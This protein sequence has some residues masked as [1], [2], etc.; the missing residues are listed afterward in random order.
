MGLFGKKRVGV[1][2]LGL[3]GSRVA[4]NLRQAGH[5]VFVWNR[6]PR[7]EPNFLGSIE[8]LARQCPV[9][10][11]FVS[12]DEALGSCCG[13][14]AG[15]VGSRHVIIN[16]ATVSPQA[17]A[18]AAQRVRAAGA[19]FLNAPFTGSRQAAEEAQL[20]YYVGGERGHLESVRG[21]LDASSR[22]ILHVG[23]IEDAAVLKIATNLVSAAINQG[24]A[25]ALALTTSAGLS[26]ERLVEAIE[27]NAARS[28]VSDLKLPKMIAGDY[29][30][31]FELRHMFKDVSFAIDLA[32]R[33][34]TDLPVANAAAACLLGA[35]TRGD[36]GSDFAAVYKSFAGSAAGGGG[37]EETQTADASVAAAA[38]SAAAAIEP[39][40]EPAS[41]SAAQPAMPAGGGEPVEAQAALVPPANAGGEADPPELFE[42]VEQA[43][44]QAAVPADEQADETGPAQSP[45]RTEVAA[46]EQMQPQ[47][48]WRIELP[49]AGDHQEPQPQELPLSDAHSDEQDQSA[50]DRREPWPEAGQDEPAAGEPEQASEPEQAGEPEQAS[51]SEPSERR[52][53][54][55]K[56]ILPPREPADDPLTATSYRQAEAEDDAP[57][58]GS[59][60]AA[61]RQPPVEPVPLQVKLPPRAD[62]AETGTPGEAVQP[63]APPPTP[64]T[65]PP[66]SPGGSHEQARAGAGHN[67]KLSGPVRSIYAD[68]ARFRPGRSA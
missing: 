15:A 42:R 28:G 9:I 4:S 64:P 38:A 26:G 30:P 35:I 21:I 39:E 8:Q 12:D 49:A 6:S 18:S 56:I 29:T 48:D 2:G 20:V 68:R 7:A 57:E 27:Y 61:E 67:V 16:H 10:Q 43:D 59:A 65:P 34:G 14:L 24:L 63:A 31:H 37:D 23:G 54:I 50:G 52:E 46:E 53:S 19:V 3:I 32:E 45:G 60:P 5:P 40:A 41:E 55:P 22:K 13:A 66:A 62:A 58:P 1:L 25:E 11:I 51:E 36:G 17:A 47:A 33:A 44:E